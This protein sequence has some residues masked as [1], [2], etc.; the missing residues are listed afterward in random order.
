MTENDLLRAVIE[1]AQAAGYRVHHQRPG[2][3][4]KGKWVSAIQGNP[5]WPDLVI[6]GKGRFIVAELKSERGIASPDQRH[7]IHRLLEAQIEVHLW[8]PSHWTDGTIAKA[9]DCDG[10]MI[11]KG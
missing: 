7:W 8:R 9:L 10:G 6:C 4:R 11:R 3:T 1:L 5:G 2:M